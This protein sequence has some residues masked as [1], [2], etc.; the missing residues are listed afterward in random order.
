MVTS[1]RASLRSVIFSVLLASPA[2]PNV[3][4]SRYGWIAR[5]KICA[6]ISSTPENW[7]KANTDSEFATWLTSNSG[8][9]TPSA[10]AS[11]FG[12]HPTDLQCGIGSS[13]TCILPSCQGKSSIMYR[14]GMYRPLYLLDFQT[15]KSNVWA[16]LVLSAVVN[17]NTFWNNVY[18]W[19]SFIIS[20]T[21]N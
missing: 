15:T 17:L 7:V 16:Y 9:P 8:N 10:L 20:N 18:V 5:Q 1:S 6:N 14:N 21:M 4:A 13:M 2:I 3:G 12:S 19:S 11:Q